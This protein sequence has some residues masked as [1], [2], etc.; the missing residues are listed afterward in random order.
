[1]SRS[2]YFQ[3][4]RHCLHQNLEV[5]NAPFVFVYRYCPTDCFDKL[6]G[7]YRNCVGKNIYFFHRETLNFRPFFKKFI[8]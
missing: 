4:R 5:S 2:I 6:P 8:V 7:C 3:V 1:M